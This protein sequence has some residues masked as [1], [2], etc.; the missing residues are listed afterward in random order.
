M[1]LDLFPALIGAVAV[2]A[3][4]IFWDAAPVRPA[5]E[6]GLPSLDEVFPAER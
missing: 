3:A 4:Q 1:V 6:A 5:D 2:Y